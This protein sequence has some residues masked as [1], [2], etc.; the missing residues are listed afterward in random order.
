[1]VEVKHVC[2]ENKI[3][4][5]HIGAKTAVNAALSNLYTQS[6]KI[7]KAKAEQKAAEKATDDK[8]KKALE[9]AES[10][11]EVPVVE[12]AIAA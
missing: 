8:N 3:G 4:E 6:E 1:K 12:T 9:A 10:V 7:S 11:A 5:Y 2:F